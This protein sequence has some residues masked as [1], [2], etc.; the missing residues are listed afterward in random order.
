MI[1]HLKSI[2]VFA[3]VVHSGQFRVAA[4]RL[5]ITPSAVSYHI[6]TLEEAVGTPLLY[7]STRRF[8]LTA[9]GEKLFKSAELMLNAAQAGFSSAQPS[10]AGLSGHLKVTLTTALS[11]SF[12][13][14]RITG[15]VLDHPNVDLHLHFDNRETDLVA[16]GIDIAIR[17][18]KLRDS[19]LLCKLIWDMPRILVASPEFVQRHGP[20]EGPEDL[21]GVTWIRFASMENQRTLYAPNGTKIQIEQAG[22]LTVNSIE[23]MVD[24]TIYGAGLSSPPTHFVESKLTSGELVAC[25]TDHRIP[26]LPVYA[27]W[28]RTTVPNLVVREF[29]DRLAGTS[30]DG[31]THE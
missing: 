16:E 3:E 4:D 12:I 29:I 11:H 27:I 5:K 21:R 22:N 8:T 24:L 1:E 18:G 13:S 2:A 19:S 17:I 28:H 7:R 30:A 10:R 25:L 23:A 9:S 20:F 14:R 15:F 6:R 26:D 31:K